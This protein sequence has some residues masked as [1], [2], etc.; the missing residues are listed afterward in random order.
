VEKEREI[1][2]EAASKE[3]KPSS[4]VEKMV[5]GRLKSFYAEKVLL[6]Q[7]FVKDPAVSIGT[8]AQQQGLKLKKFIH[9]ELG[10]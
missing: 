1:L 9:W 8:L 5:E 4:I 7:P 3:G 10:H 6:E 2:R